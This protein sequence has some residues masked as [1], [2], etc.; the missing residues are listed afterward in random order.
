MASTTP[1][2]TTRVGNAASKLWKYEG[3]PGFAKWMASSDDFFVLR[4]FGQ[5]NT[6]VLLLMQDRIKRKEEEL[7]NIDERTRNGPDIEAL[8]IA[9]GV[10]LGKRDKWF[11]IN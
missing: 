10:T 2:N 9:S 6:R 1:T 8:P 4:R 7:F 5:M 3:Y 11:L